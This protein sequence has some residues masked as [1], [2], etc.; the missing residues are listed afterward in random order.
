VP[1]ATSAVAASRGS[2]HQA[3]TRARWRRAHAAK[4]A[5]GATSHSTSS[6]VW[7]WPRLDGSWS[8][9]DVDVAVLTVPILAAKDHAD[10]VVRMVL[11]DW[12]HYAAARKPRVREDADL[13]LDEFGAIDGGPATD[14]LERAR[15]VGGR[16]IVA[17]QSA[18]SLGRDTWEV[19]RLLGAC[20]GGIVLHRCPDPDEL[21]RAAGT[22]RAT[23]QSWQLD[24]GGASGLGN[25]LMRHKMKVSPDAVR[26]ATTGRRG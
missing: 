20:A 17:G 25:V 2:S 23:E 15:D 13:V 7:A 21:L 10:A 6:R 12:R 14:L 1:A 4:A 8:F 24:T 9:E 16:V 3:A 18:E 26:Q 11:A 22:V 5:S 19:R